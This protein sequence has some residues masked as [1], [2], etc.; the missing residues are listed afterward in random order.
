MLIKEI[1]GT[2]AADKHA[3]ILHRPSLKCIKLG[4]NEGD[5]MTKTMSFEASRREMLAA[6][7]KCS[8]KVET[9]VIHFKE[10]GVLE[11]L[12]KVD[13]F[14]KASRKSKFMCG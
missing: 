4:F 12:K 11:F 8:K 2:R 5:D 7:K 6:I 13:A 14:E 9:K 1:A 3:K 10:N